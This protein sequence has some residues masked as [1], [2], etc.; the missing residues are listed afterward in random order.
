[1]KAFQW[2]NL[3]HVGLIWFLQPHPKI[4]D[5]PWHTANFDCLCARS[6]D[7][8]P[9]QVVLPPLLSKEADG[10]QYNA[11]EDS[12]LKGLLSLSVALGGRS[13]KAPF[14]TARSC[15]PC[16]VSEPMASNHWVTRISCHAHLRDV[17]CHNGLPSTG[18]H[19][20]YTWT[21]RIQISSCCF[22]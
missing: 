18:N 8:S 17:D 9:K 20:F 14:V 21:S 10:S 4:C 12:S 3:E 11:S 5:V 7:T 6:H 22:F 2:G 15:F 19:P 16:D 1:M 13:L